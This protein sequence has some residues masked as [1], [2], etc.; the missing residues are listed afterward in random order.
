MP[1]KKPKIKLDLKNL[2]MLSSYFD[3]ILVHL[4]QKAH[5]RPNLSPKFLSTLGPNPTRK[6]RPDLQLSF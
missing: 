6:A 3:Y 2:A 5:L 1:E 4:T